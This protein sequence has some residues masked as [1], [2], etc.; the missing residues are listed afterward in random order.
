MLKNYSSEINGDFGVLVMVHGY[1][2][3][4]IGGDDIADPDFKKNSL[5]EKDPPT[6]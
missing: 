1:L 2:V 6:S 3:N 5:N 4:D